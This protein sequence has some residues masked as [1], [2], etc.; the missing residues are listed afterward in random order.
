M[1]SQKPL[2]EDLSSPLSGLGWLATVA[3]APWL[4]D[5]P[6]VSVQVSLFKD[7]SH[8]IGTHPIPV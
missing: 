8:G 2:G 7:S 1:L 5:T 3:G 4:I 6:P